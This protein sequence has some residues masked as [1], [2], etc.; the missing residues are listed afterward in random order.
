MAFNV[1]KCKVV[2]FGRSN[3]K[4]EYKMLG[5]KLA[6]AEAERDIG[7]EVQNNLKPSKQCQVGT[8]SNHK[9]IPL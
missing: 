9:V 2:H 4:Y 3:K 1:K 5:E 8:K 7:V 6:E